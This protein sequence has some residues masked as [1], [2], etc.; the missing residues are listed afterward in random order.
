M[1]M[2]LRAGVDSIEHPLPRSDAAIALMARRGIASVPTFVPYR[3]VMRTW[4]G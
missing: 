2:A 1:N 4:D 3:L